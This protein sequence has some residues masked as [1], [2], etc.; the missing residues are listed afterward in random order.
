VVLLFGALKAR[1]FTEGWYGSK[2][3]V[4][5]LITIDNLGAKAGYKER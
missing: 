4:H 2:H 1:L 3:S 5:R